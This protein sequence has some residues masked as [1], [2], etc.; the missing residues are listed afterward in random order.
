MTKIKVKELIS[1]FHDTKYCKP[2]ALQMLDAKTDE[3]IMHCSFSS[4]KNINETI[5][6]ADVICCDV[7][8]GVLRIVCED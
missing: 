1:L 3:Y 8:S 2:A 4:W 5:L 7:N 6:N